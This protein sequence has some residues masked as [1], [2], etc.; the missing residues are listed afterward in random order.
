MQTEFSKR[1]HM[2]VQQIPKGRVS[3]YGR[4]AILAGN[5]RGARGVGYTLHHNKTPETTPCH[6]VV[7]ADGSLAPSYAFGGEERQREILR[8]EGVLFLPDGRVDIKTCQWP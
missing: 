6:R 5:P 1:V 7:F 8:E 4:I 2:A 3:T